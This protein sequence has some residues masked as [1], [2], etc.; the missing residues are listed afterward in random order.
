ME[1]RDR[2][3]AQTVTEKLSEE[4][5][6][7]EALVGDIVKLIQMLDKDMVLRI[8]AENYFL[9]AT[10][11]V[12][13]L[14]KDLNSVEGGP[15]PGGSLLLVSEAEGREEHRDKTRP[16]ING[17]MLSLQQMYNTSL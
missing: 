5:K 15:L 3:K 12:E 10:E 9:E 7:H 11:N 4:E 1:I 13:V 8:Q 14:R 16:L 6:K 2:T 17:W